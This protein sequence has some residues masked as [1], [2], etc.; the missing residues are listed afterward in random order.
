M[1]DF[2]KKSMIMGLGLASMTKE[3]IETM[4]DELSKYSKMTEEEG[5]KLAD[6]LQ[7]ESV[8]ARD[9]MQAT[10]ARMVDK[11]VSKMPCDRRINALEARIAELE[12]AA[13]I[14]HAAPP[15]G[16]PMPGSTCCC[17]GTDA[18][19]PFPKPDAPV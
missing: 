10:I 11:A 18:D 2:I 13:G 7:K 1:M 4:A 9:D 15:V 12:R 17:A 16:E 19:I 3:R 14:P 5:Q 6:Y 8:K